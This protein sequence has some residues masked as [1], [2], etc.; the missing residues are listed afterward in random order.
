MTSDEEKKELTI[1]GIYQ[2]AG[3]LSV[4]GVP[5]SE[6]QLEMSRQLIE[7]IEKDEL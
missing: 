4:K 1:S 7:K 5:M 3:Y 2:V 6:S